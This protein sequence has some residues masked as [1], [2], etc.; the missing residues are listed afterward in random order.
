MPLLTPTHCSCHPPLPPLAALS[1]VSHF[2][3]LPLA[4][5][6]VLPLS[7]TSILQVA[8]L[9]ATA[10]THIDVTAVPTGLRRC[11]VCNIGLSTPVRMQQHLRGR[12][13]CEMIARCY[14]RNHPE[15]VDPDND[16]A[17][18]AYREH[19]T[20]P[21]SRCVVEPPDLAAELLRSCLPS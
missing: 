19:C 13:H 11:L 16:A 1:H 17:A 3:H 5:S 15:K 18:A 9:Q 10:R 7:Y 20:L 6:S 21:L 2:P 8:A 14:L 12:G 4:P